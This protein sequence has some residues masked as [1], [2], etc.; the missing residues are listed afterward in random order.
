[1]A[2]HC[3]N[4]QTFNFEPPLRLIQTGS[5]GYKYIPAEKHVCKRLG[6]AVNQWVFSLVWIQ[7]FRRSFIMYIKWKR[8]LLKRDSKPFLFFY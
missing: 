1:M 4:T 8:R 3:K 2:S 7:L 6:T 5:S